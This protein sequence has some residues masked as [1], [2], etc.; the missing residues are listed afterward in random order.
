VLELLY[1]CLKNHNWSAT[2]LDDVFL[3]LTLCCM[4]IAKMVVVAVEH[5]WKQL[6]FSEK[7]TEGEGHKLAQKRANLMPL[8]L[9]ASQ[10]F[11]LYI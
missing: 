5:K 10:Y 3:E 1:G 8:V 7:E 2:Y 4:Q 6:L 11:C 9:S